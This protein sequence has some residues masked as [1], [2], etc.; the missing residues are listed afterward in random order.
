MQHCRLCQQGERLALLKQQKAKSTNAKAW[1]KG[2]LAAMDDLELARF[3]TLLK[4]KAAAAAALEADETE[5]LRLHQQRVA[6][7]QRQAKAKLKQRLWFAAAVLALICALSSVALPD[8]STVARA[9][10]AAIFGAICVACFLT[11]FLAGFVITHGPASAKAL[12]KQAKSRKGTLLRQFETNIRSNYEDWEV[13]FNKEMKANEALLA[14]QKAETKALRRSAKIA[15]TTVITDIGK[16]VDSYDQIESQQQQQ[17][18]STDAAA[19]TTAT[20]TTTTA[21]VGT[22]AIHLHDISSATM[23]TQSH[24]VEAGLEAVGD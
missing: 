9:A 14:A 21:T 5:K 19:T 10:I 16:T 23:L 1:E 7:P 3:Q 20:S 11:G 8:E 24:I 17:P 22:G 2:N 12:A 4:A 18:E 6:L 13:K 15:A